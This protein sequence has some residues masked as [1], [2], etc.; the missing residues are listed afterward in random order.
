MNAP[1]I[2]FSTMRESCIEIYQVVSELFDLGAHIGV[3][4]LFP[5]RYATVRS[6]DNLRTDES[7]KRWDDMCRFA[8]DLHDDAAF[9]AGL[10]DVPVMVKRS[11]QEGRFE[12]TKAGAKRNLLEQFYSLGGMKTYEQK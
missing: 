12:W 1:Q 2:D 5:G 3:P 7:T 6:A 9:W 11:W 4:I 8:K 10:P